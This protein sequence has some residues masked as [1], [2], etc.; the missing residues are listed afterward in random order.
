VLEVLAQ[1]DNTPPR[2]TKVE[3][4][5]PSGKKVMRP[6]APITA[7]DRV[8]QL[9]DLARR[10]AGALGEPSDAQHEPV[11]KSLASAH[12]AGINAPL[13]RDG[14]DELSGTLRRELFH[15][16]TYISNAA[17]HLDNVKKLGEQFDTMAA[18]L[19]PVL[20][21]LDPTGAAAPAKRVGL[22]LDDELPA[23]NRSSLVHDYDPREHKAP[24]AADPVAPRRTASGGFRTGRELPSSTTKPAPAIGVAADPKGV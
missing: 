12:A 21:Q 17:A 8:A 14:S 6:A 9:L 10:L 23:G 16:Q 2:P 15:S 7:R 4:T 1:V 11:T 3:A 18:E 13:A 5:L 24:A 22:P 20:D 19:K